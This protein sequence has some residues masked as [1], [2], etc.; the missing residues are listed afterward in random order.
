[1][2][3]LWIFLYFVIVIPIAVFIGKFI[4]KGDNNI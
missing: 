3:W 2:W 1:M 4:N